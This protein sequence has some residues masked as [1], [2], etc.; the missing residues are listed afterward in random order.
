MVDGNTDGSGV[1]SGDTGSL[2]LLERETSTG[3]DLSVVSDGGG[4]DNGSQQ[5][6]RSGSDGGGLLGSRQSSSGLLAGLV[7]VGL[8]PLLP[9]LSEM[10]LD[11]G[12][13]L[14]DSWVS[15]CF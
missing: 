4:S 8:D 7:K 2:E 3:S 5:I 9:V 6:Q 14:T 1:G 11:E 10:V 15:F 13:V 12:V